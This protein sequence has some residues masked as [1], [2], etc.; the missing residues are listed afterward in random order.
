MAVDVLST[1]FTILKF[2]HS[3]VQSIK[4]SKEQLG[5]L[6][7]CAEELL[8]ALDMEFSES[9]LVPEKCSKALEDLA[10]LLR[11][12]HRFVETEKDSGLLKML[13]QKDGRLSKIEVF[14]RRIGMS[15]AA[16]QIPSLLSIQTMLAE[17]KKAQA[18]D[19]EALHTYLSA[20]EKNNAKLLH[21]LE[22]NQ[23]NTIAMM[24]CIQKQ[25]NKKNVDRAEQ[26]FYT[27][28]LEYL[29]SRSGKRVKVEDWMIASFEVEYEDSEEIGAGGFGKV[30]RG[31]WNR[32]EVAIKVLQNEAGVKPSPAIWSKLRHPNILQFLGANTLDD[33]PFLVMPY[34]P[35]N[36]KDFLKQR[37]TFERL[38]ILRD[39]SLGLE[40]LHSR[41]ICHG[42]LKGINVLVDNSERALL[43]DF[44]LARLR[45]DATVRTS[46]VDALQIQG[47]RNW[48]APELLDGSPPR[49]PSDVYAFGMVVYE[50]YTGDIPL[51]SVP[52]ADLV[53]LVVHRGRRPQRPGPH[54]GRS[55]PDELWQLTEQYWAADPY[56][57]PTATQIH[58]KIRHMASYSRV[59]AGNYLNNNEAPM[60]Q[61][62]RSQTRPVARMSILIDGTFRHALPIQTVTD[63]PTA[64]ATTISASAAP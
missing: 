29:T 64:N 21:T 45:A 18:R 32:T 1:A 7:T 2:I 8:T 50:L 58:D 44:G 12:I 19:T 17:S 30:Y 16:F 5:L 60:V 37:P 43:C 26:E 33:K 6:A 48:M 54:E 10:T 25:L 9:R 52:Y 31:T 34:L 4:T 49:L 3:C 28:T 59:E 24:V 11:D 39:I 57:R 20:L 15:I 42:D 14:Y 35:Y 47:S 55:I 23:N 53:D 61:T 13:L 40:Y 56:E 63:R 36:A 62:V 46:T 38:C 27:H 41:G 51:F 22:I